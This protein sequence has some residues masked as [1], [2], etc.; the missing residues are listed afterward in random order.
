MLYQQN[1]MM[2]EPT[3]EQMAAQQR[4]MKIM[5]GVMAVLF[6]KVAAG[7]S[8]YFIISTSWGIIERQFIPKPKVDVDDFGG[9]GGGGGGG[10][11]GGPPAPPKP[12]GFLGRLQAR[13]SERLE[14]LQKQADEQSSRQQRNNPNRP[15]PI[16]NPDRRDGGGRDKKKKR[17]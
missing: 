10:G 6:Y 9:G 5:M 16:R 15:Q 13:L 3:D 7:L 11:K 8:L 14:E 17:K 2:P 1:K 4:M 12:R